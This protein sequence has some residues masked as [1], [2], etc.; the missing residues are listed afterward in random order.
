MGVL[1]RTIESAPTRPRDNA[2]DDLIIVIIKII[3]GISSKN[4]GRYCFWSTTSRVALPTMY[5]QRIARTTPILKFAVNSTNGM[6][7][8]I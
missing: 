1:N 5:A 8:T 3:V 7:V 2:I 6:S 4:I